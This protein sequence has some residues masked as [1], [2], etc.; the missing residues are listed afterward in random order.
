[1]ASCREVVT[2]PIEVFDDTVVNNCNLAGCV[3]MRVRVFVGRIAVSGPTRVPDSDGTDS[4]GVF[5]QGAEAGINAALP[6]SN[7]DLISA[8]NCNP[9][10]IVTPVFEA[11]EAFDDDL[12]GLFFADISVNAAHE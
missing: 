11:S 3:E 7:F 1:M 8:V 12:A 6:F 9:G 2:K 4:R 5:E 10:A